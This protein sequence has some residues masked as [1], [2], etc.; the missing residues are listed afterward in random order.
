MANIANVRIWRL[1]LLRAI[2]ALAA[3]VAFGLA[4]VAVP[5][6]KAQSESV[7]Y[8]FTGG[9]DGYIPYAGLLMDTAGNL[10]G[11]TFAGTVF[12]LDT[13]S[14]LTVLHTL[15]GNSEAGLIMDNAGNLYG[16]TNDGGSNNCSLGCGTVFKLDTSGNLTV[17]HN[18][19]G[20]PGDGANPQA[21]LLMDTAGNLYGTTFDGGTGTCVAPPGSGCGTVFKIDSSGNETVLHYFTG[22]PDGEVPDFAGLI[23]DTAGNLYGTTAFGGASSNGTVFKID[24]S[25]NETVLHSFAGF[26]GD[27][28]N[29]S[30]A[31]IMD[32]RGNLYGT[33]ETGGASGFGTVF[34]LSTS[35]KE[36][37][38]YNFTGSPDGAAPLASL[39]MDKKGRLYGTTP[40][41]GAGTCSFVAPGCGTVFRLS[42]SGKETVLHRFEGSLGDG[43]IPYASL[44]MD[45]AGNLYGTTTSGG[46]SGNCSG[47]CGTVFKLIP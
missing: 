22:P 46:A 38:L 3:L 18:F 28:A 2:A 19:T 26:P 40:D 39:I 42:T 16:T 9:S 47:G 36:T 6:A 34:K 17:L 15:P 11:T 27:G 24:T 1:R 31:L 23:I 45:T 21:G 7:L 41:G 20:S 4:V 5:S 32:K 14:N 13:S 33:T 12:K 35:G 10:Y 30:A 44:V 8:S 43:A 37:V 29:P 25:G